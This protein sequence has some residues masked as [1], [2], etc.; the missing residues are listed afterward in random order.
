MNRKP[1]PNNNEEFIESEEY[2]PIS[3]LDYRFFEYM[4]EG[5]I[6]S[7]PIYEGSKVVDLIIKYA[8]LVAYR[9]RKD[10][11]D[12]LI[13][14]SIKEIYDP[15]TVAF[16]LEKANK[17]VST[18]R[19][20][21]YEAY[22][23]QADKYL[24]ITAFLPMQDLYVTFST[25]ITEQKKAAERLNAEKQKLLD[26]IEFLPDATFVIDECGVVIA[27]NKALEEMTGVPKKEIIGKDDYI[28]SIPF[29]GHKRPI[30]ID[31]IF[32][33]EEEV[34]SK[35]TY[36]KRE[37]ENLFAEVFVNNLFEGKGAYVFVKASPL[38]DSA[39]KLVGSIETV[40]DITRQKKDEIALLKSEEKFRSTIEQ[41]IDG[42]YV[43]D[44]EGAIIEWNKG[45]EKITGHK[46]EEELG[47]PLWESQYKLLPDEEKTPELYDYIK[48]TIL[49][50][51]QTGDVDWINKPL[52]HRIKRPDGEIRY[53]QSVTYPIRTEKGTIIGSITRDISEQK[54]IGEKL[55]N[56]QNLLNTVL[57]SIP[58]AVAVAEAP[59]GKLIR[60]NEQFEK[61]WEQPFIPSKNIEDY[62][63]YK[64][65]HPDGSQYKPEEWPLARSITAGEVV[66]SEEISVLFEDGTRKVLIVSSTPIQD[67][68]EKIIL[69]VVIAADITRRKQAE[70][71]LMESEEKFAKAFYSNSAGMVI[72]DTNGKIIEVNEAYAKITGYKREELLG[73]SIIDLNIISVE[74]RDAVNKML[75]EGTFIYNERRVIQNKDGEERIVMFTVEFIEYAGEKRVFSIIYD[76]NDL[77]KAH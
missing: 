8:N 32:L 11:K 16:E 7:A 35:Y 28:Y 27:W 24:S 14:K 36:V 72:T 9:Q 17:V 58:V 61:I 54:K 19:G 20:I 63:A 43:I 52:D 3:E 68:S 38:Y 33:S 41:S 30:I 64:G 22:R 51:L 39:G 18:G 50:F 45:M 13:D 74:E 77:K 66:M 26:I 4:Q 53:V 42:I 40:R 12:G 55:K 59:S 49:Q 1:D 25:D 76:I 70:E 37:G 23:P 21:K 5:V 69:G 62:S 57:N 67:E 75:T 47:Q 71:L 65:F 10:L 29:Y 56:E 34:E 46:R 2:G 60:A 48:G 73:N 44:E 6:V 31:L 15:E